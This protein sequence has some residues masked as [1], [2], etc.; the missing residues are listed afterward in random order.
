MKKN[1]LSLT[2][3]QSITSGIVEFSE[4]IIQS[5]KLKSF[6]ETSQENFQTIN[7]KVSIFAKDS[8]N[9]SSDFLKSQNVQ[10][11]KEFGLETFYLTKITIE[12]A[13]EGAKIAIN[14]NKKLKEEAKL[15]ENK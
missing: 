3:L 5:K 10:E 8:F 1:I 15:L 7:K 12:G 13:I 4:K 14:K 9:K 6:K 2:T 11:I